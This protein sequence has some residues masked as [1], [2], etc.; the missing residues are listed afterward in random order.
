MTMQNDIADYQDFE[1]AAEHLKQADF[2]TWK[3]YDKVSQATG[4]EAYDEFK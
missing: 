4:L 1:E 3:L 2:K